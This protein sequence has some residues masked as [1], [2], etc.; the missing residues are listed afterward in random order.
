MDS[1]DDDEKAQTCSPPQMQIELGCTIFNGPSRFFEDLNNFSKK[2]WKHRNKVEDK[3]N[4]KFKMI[5]WFICGSCFCLKAF[6]F[7]LSAG[8]PLE[9]GTSICYLLQNTSCNHISC[10]ICLF[11]SSCVATFVFVQFSVEIFHDVA[12]GGRVKFIKSGRVIFFWQISIL[13]KF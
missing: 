8:F 12:T 2:D 6:S 9:S 11:F 10:F 1:N 4:C 7:N 3:E 13:V 5:S